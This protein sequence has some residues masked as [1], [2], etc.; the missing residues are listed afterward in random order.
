VLVDR[1]YWQSVIHFERLAEFGMVNRADLDLF[2]FA[3]DA[4][5]I[6]AELLS[7][8]LEPHA[9]IELTREQAKP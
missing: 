7:R 3:E 5:G 1:D 4:E 9:S 2:G 6:W 8:G